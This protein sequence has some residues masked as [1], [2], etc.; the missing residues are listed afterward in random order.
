[1]RNISG[2]NR[3]RSLKLQPKAR[4]TNPY[5]KVVI[6]PAKSDIDHVRYERLR[7]FEKVR[8]GLIK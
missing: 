7:A 1:M 3:A 2:D 6:E 4:Q 8:Q 5:C